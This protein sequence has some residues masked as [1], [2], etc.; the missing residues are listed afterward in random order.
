[1]SGEVFVALLATRTPSTGQPSGSSTWPVTRKPDGCPTVTTALA[2]ATPPFRSLTTHRT[3]CSPGLLQLLD[4]QGRL[5]VEK[6]SS[7]NVQEYASASPSGSSAA[8]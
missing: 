8:A 4:V 3:M 1:M 6:L 5:L 7:S 2:L